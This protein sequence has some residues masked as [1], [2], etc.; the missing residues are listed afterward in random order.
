VSNF[1]FLQKEFPDWFSAVT[2]A[3]AYARTDP[4]S[5]CFYTRRTLELAVHWL[6][7]NDSS[8][9]RPYDDSLNSLVSH[10]SFQKN[11]PPQIRTKIDYLRKQGNRA[12]HDNR[13]VHPSDALGCL[14]ELFHV[15]YY[16]AKT[17]Q[18]DLSVALPQVF[19]EALLPPSASDVKK[20]S[21][22]QLQK[23]SEDIAKRDQVLLAQNKALAD[24]EA[25]VTALQAQV[26]T[27]K[28]RNFSIPD[29]HD[30]S[31]A[32]T[33]ERIIDLMLLEA[34]WNPKG[35]NVS[36]Y[37]VVGMVS[38]K[39]GQGS[40]DYVLWGDNGL[41]LALVE[42]KRT[43]VDVQKGREQAKEYAY[44]LEKM[45]GQRPLIFYTNGYSTYLWDDVKYPPREV[46]GFYTKDECER[47]LQRRGNTT[48]VVSVAV[49]K[50]VADRYYQQENIRRVAERF[51]EG[52]REALLVMA[53]G[54]GK[55]RTAI[56][57]VDVLMRAGLV[58]RVLF[59]ADRK[60]LV[61]QTV[62]AFK[63]HL[64]S[65]SPVNLLGEKEALESRV[66]VSTYHTMMGLIDTFEKGKRT[67]GVGHFDLVIVDE[68]H[69]SVYKTFGAIFAYFDSLLIGLTATPK[70][71]VD[72]NT[73]DL[74]NVEDGVPTFAYDLDEAIAD[75]YLVPPNPM[76]VPTKFLREGI[77]YDDLSDEEKEAWEK[78]EW[79]T[80]TGDPA[81][82]PPEEVRAADLNRWLFNKDTVDK[83]LAQ[84][85][86]H[87][88]KVKGGDRLGK[89]I[90]FA[91]NHEHAVFISER[92]DKNYP[93]YAGHFARVIDNYEPK[94]ESLIEAFSKKDS[95][96]HIAISVDM[97]DTGV[98]VP[99]TV[100]LVFFKLVRSKTKFFQ[101]LGRGTRLCPEL[102]GPSDHK[103]H[104]NIFDACQNFEFFNAHPK[105]LKTQVTEPL[106]ERLFKLR[107]ELLGALVHD[108][109]DLSKTIADD[110]HAYVS[111]MPL[112]NFIVRP[113]RQYLEPFLERSR[114]N[115]LTGS[116][117]AELAQHVAP[118]P[119]PFQDED[120]TAK[121][122]D[123]LLVQLQ[124]AK[125]QGLDFFKRQKNRVMEIAQGLESKAKNVPVIKAQ[126]P[127]IQEVQTE[128]FWQE[129]NL[130]SLETVRLA[131]RG[132]AQFIDGKDRN[133]LYSDFSDE[134]NEAESVAVSYLT[135]G[136]NIAQYKKKVEGFIRAHLKDETIQ[137]IR[138]GEWLE[139]KDLERLEDLLF[140]AKE[141]ESR[142]TFER[143]YGKQ[144]NLGLFIRRLVGLD[145][146]AAKRAFARY[147]DDKEFSSEQIRFVNF[148]IDEL[149]QNG[150]IDIPLL[151]DR[152]FTDLH[153]A[154]LDGVFTLQEASELITLIG[155]INE[156][157]GNQGRLEAPL[158]IPVS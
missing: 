63:K 122:F 94:A 85:M 157:V 115:T 123:A 150:E 100:N 134:L 141:L 116:D 60:T 74:F 112:E 66:V 126:L 125:A 133:I 142:E 39:T 19:D 97:L 5:S 77:K 121:R 30:Y 43:S 105:G 149:T 51:K 48:D 107:L 65:A 136:V 140:S 15:M 11:I 49:N 61:S 135:G 83:I 73:Y 33:R 58:K 139:A 146:K 80:L 120:E 117:R 72:C 45:H 124:L 37:P 106:S 98:D 114:W 21:A 78:L 23:L 8:F 47:T 69:R 90:I 130:E 71:E 137:K 147:L 101:M 103:T 151:Y 70:D 26:A 12:V 1:A 144:A 145:R 4:R 92:F 56:A 99:E 111:A 152:P 95:E 22:A 156:S 84:L 86:T 158:R 41:P 76:S 32:E 108:D 18:R 52:Y 38:R 28:A 6:F 131:L 102:F 148:I 104:F 154:G 24:Y 87:G 89:T 25:K 10:S 81:Q 62:K 31:E 110:L 16:L 59:L 153:E 17:Y 119:S 55:T 132:L 57:L 67:F 35:E 128:T 3:E 46:Q 34:G 75:Q 64:P 143:A 68:A 2:F 14:K 13:A 91:Q 7:D 79:A 54:T 113:K 138:T 155:G 129:A 88:V 82:V 118:L 40:V 20:Q 50:A 44:C 27:T 127:L 29:K 36:E 42:A 9:K 109:S 53:T 93:H 96:P